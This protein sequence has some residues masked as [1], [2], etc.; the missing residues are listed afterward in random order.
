MGVGNRF[1]VTSHTSPEKATL[2]GGLA[3]PLSVL[4]LRRPGIPLRGESQLPSRACEAVGA[5]ERGMQ[6]LWGV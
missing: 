4:V 3:R 5:A 1:R 6:A 2:M